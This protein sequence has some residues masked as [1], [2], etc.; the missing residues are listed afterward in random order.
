M[1]SH[2]FILAFVAC[3]FGVKSR[4]SFPRPVS[5]DFSPLFSSRSCRVSESYVQVFNPFQVHVCESNF[6][7]LPMIIQFSQHHLL[8]RPSF[9]HWIFLAPLSHISW[10]DMCKFISGLS[11]L[12]HWS[13]CL[14]LCWYCTVLI[15]MAFFPTFLA[16]PEHME[17]LDQG[18]EWSCSFHLHCSCHDTL[19]FNSLGW[20]GDRTLCPGAGRLSW[21]FCTTAGTPDYSSF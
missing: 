11:L 13:R 16:A 2:L 1:E 15:I 21:S 18:S 17:F 8:K 4:K 7:V 20:P 10:L 12:F 5:R 14:F 19:S 6:I 9:L 3:A